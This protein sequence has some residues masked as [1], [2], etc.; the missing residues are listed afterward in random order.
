MSNFPFKIWLVKLLKP[1]VAFALKH[2]VKLHDF[3]DALKIALVESV[4]D[5][6]PALSNITQI[7]LRTGI[8]RAEVKRLLENP[9]PLSERGI[10]ARVLGQ[11]QSDKRFCKKGGEPRPLSCSGKNSEF[12][13]LLSSISKNLSIY[14]ILLELERSNLVARENGLAKLIQ[15]EYRIS[16]NLNDLMRVL[17]ADIK[18][19]LETVEKNQAREPNQ[20]NLHIR[21]HYD[22]IAIESIPLLRR[23]ILKEGTLFHR[24]IQQLIAQ[25]DKDIN[26]E[27]ED[28]QGGGQITLVSFAND[29]S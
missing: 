14:S 3:E 9:T 22:N 26:P 12:E 5:Q 28:Q 25:H 11:W 20:T 6:N 21:T 17:S 16:D 23:E 10:L 2:S 8:H 24:K 29:Q 18:D 15:G 4:S 7:S 1:I 19:L 27:L 13:Q